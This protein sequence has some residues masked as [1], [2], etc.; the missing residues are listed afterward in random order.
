LKILRVI[1]HSQARSDIPRSDVHLRSWIRRRPT[2]VGAVLGNIW[3]PKDVH[4]HLPPVHR[5]ECRCL[6]R[7]VA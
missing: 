3:S 6:W 2:A 4:L 1:P 7:Q 5:V